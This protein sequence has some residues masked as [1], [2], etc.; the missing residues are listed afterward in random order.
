MNL[1]EREMVGF[2]LWNQHEYGIYL[3]VHLAVVH[4]IS[5]QRIKACVLYKS[6]TPP[7]LAICLNI[8]YAALLAY[9]SARY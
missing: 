6:Q 7:Q 4:Y 8:Q 9:Q 5:P 3:C 2:S 1:T